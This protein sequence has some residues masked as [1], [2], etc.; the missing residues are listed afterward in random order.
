VLV[1]AGGS[2]GTPAGA[3]LKQV[4]P[5]ID[6]NLRT[7]A[8]KKARAVAGVS[9]G[10]LGAFHYTQARPDLYSQTASLSGDI[11][12]S[13]NSMDL[14]MAVAVAVTDALGTMCA[15]SSGYC[16]PDE[17][18]FKPGADSDA[19]FGSPYPVFNVGWR[20]NQVDPA[21]HMDRLAGTG[22]SNYT[23]GGGA[24]LSTW[25]SGWRARSRTSRHAWTPWAC[26]P[27]TSTTATVQAG[28]PV[29]R[30]SH[31]G[32]LGTGSPGPDS[33]VGA[34]LRLLTVDAGIT[35]DQD[36]SRHPHAIRR[37]GV[38]PRCET[39]ADLHSNS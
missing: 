19:L 36:G 5:F 32:P 38:P 26:P 10:G 17:S 21:Q 30:R 18:A 13:A 16:D 2:I 34:G 22:V 23:G 15:S 7:I 4:I 33:A 25:S 6:A 14:R 24:H 27:T 29:Q 8:T 20:W 31:R 37:G 1:L 9:L 12:L 3:D 28:R 39:A 35:G 11:D